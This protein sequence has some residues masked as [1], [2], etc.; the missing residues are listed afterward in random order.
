MNLQERLRARLGRKVALI[1]VGNSLRGDDAAGCRVAQ[2][3]NPTARARAF[4]AGDTP[5]NVLFQVIAARPDTVVFVDAVDLGAEP[6]AVALLE[7][8]E[9][10]D[11][12]PTTHRVPLRVLT[13]VLRQE[14][15][16]DVFVLGIQPG[17]VRFGSALGSRVGEAADR[18]TAIL[19]EALRATLPSP[20][21][22]R[23]EPA[24]EIGP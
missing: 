23:R 13:D 18:L 4:L 15:R 17:C 2:R 11:Y 19:D 21:A 14:T 24:R 9:L 1:G 16:A 6:G 3:L 8:D 12:C 22:A 7:C 20:S 10:A 5:E